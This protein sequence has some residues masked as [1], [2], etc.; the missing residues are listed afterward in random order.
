MLLKFWGTRGSIPSPLRPDQIQLKLI[1]ALEA[2][3]REN[4]DLTHRESI[5]KFVARLSLEASTIGSNT[6]C[7]SIELENDLIIFD[8]GSGIRE[9]G[10][11][12]MDKTNPLA[13]KFGFYQ[14]KGH[15]CIF[16]THTHWDH[17]QGF[18]FFNP[19]HVPGNKFDIYYV[20]DYVPEVLARQMEP[21]TCPVHFS[22]ISDALQFHKLEEGELIEVCG[23]T[24]TNI[25]LHHPNKAYAYRVE[26]GDAVAILATDSEYTNLD[27]TSTKKYR[28]FFA[29]ADLLIFDAMYSVRESFIKEDWGHSSALIG[30][31]I[32]RESNVKSVYFFHHDTTTTDEEIMKVLQ[33]AR[34][35]L[36]P[37]EYPQIYM[38]QEGLEIE[39]GN[40]AYIADFQID[41]TVKNGV[42][43][44]SLSGK[45]GSQVTEEFRQ[46]LTQSLETHQTDKVILKMENLSQL[47]M[48]GIR[49]LVEARKNVISLAL[50]GVPD[51]IYRVFELAGTTDFFAIY[52]DDDAALAA[53]DS[54][55]RNGFTDTPA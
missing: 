26:A 10:E 8:A 20:H 53:L 39:V 9:L 36:G 16:F 38:A 50:V 51:N 46:R 49:A 11:A 13:Q 19:V 33:A 48:A 6:T 40:S 31:D 42:V 54:R 52:E 30:V 17:I 3:G 28:D 14:G 4:I 23:A 37:A 29:N 22:R 32:A 7:V 24:I 2:A 5:E 34:E 43:F 12:L 55:R 41:E 21:E 15:A 35:Y 27:H 45:F 18:P 1:E 25:Q 44:F 47:T